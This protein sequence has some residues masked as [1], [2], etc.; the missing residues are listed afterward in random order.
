LPIYS[1]AVKETENQVL[2]FEGEFANTV[3]HAMSSGRTEDAKDVWGGSVPYLTPTS[4]ESDTK[5]EN[6]RTVSEFSTEQVLKTLSVPDK[7]IGK[8]E[9]TE[10]GGIKTVQIGNTSF[11]G[12]QI[13]SAFNLK[14][15]AFDIEETE[16]GLKFTVYG[17]GHGVGMSQYGADAFAR[18]GMSYKEILSHF[19]KGTELI[20]I[21]FKA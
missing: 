14:S 3:F 15:S 13:R 9:K 19:Y 16:N 1:Q 7:S 5:L 18:S 12:R 20:S 17:Y 6:F 4:C 2:I 21:D 10:S 11:S 8:I